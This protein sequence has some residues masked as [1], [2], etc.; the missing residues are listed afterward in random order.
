MY[1]PFQT[2]FDSFV[3]FQKQITM[4]KNFWISWHLSKKLLLEQNLPATCKKLLLEQNLSATWQQVAG[5][6]CSSS[7]FLQQVA[8]K[9]C[10]S[11][12]FLQ[13]VADKF[14]SSSSFLQQVADTKLVSYLL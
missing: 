14:C 8:D 7:S 9:F 11:S 10:S 4:M 12:S 1:I 13:Q 5:K 2:H 3:H 6:F